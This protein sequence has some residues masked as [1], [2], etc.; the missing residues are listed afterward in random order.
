MNKLLF[1]IGAVILVGVLGYGAY[2]NKNMMPDDGD[3]AKVMQKEADA[4]VMKEKEAMMAKENMTPEQMEAMKKEEA[5]KA[6]E[7]MMKKDGEV[8]QK[9]EVMIKKSAGMYVPYSSDKLALAKDNKVVIFFHAPWCPTCRALDAEITS[10]GVKE[11][12]VILKADYDTSKELKV[13]YGVTSQHTLVQVNTS[14][15][16]LGKWT[17]GDLAGIYAKAK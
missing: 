17:G 12:Y 10:K 11:G 1:G 2:E 3:K 6:G 15:A 9:E 16:S 13:K 5:M 8:M 14:G 4:M 7:T